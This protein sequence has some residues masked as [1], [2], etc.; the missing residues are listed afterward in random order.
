MQTSLSDA[1]HLAARIDER[2]AAVAGVGRRLGLDDESLVLAALFGFP[3]LAVDLADGTR[4]VNPQAAAGPGVADGM[5]ADA[6]RRAA[7]GHGKRLDAVR[8]AV[9]L[10]QGHVAFLV[11]GQHVGPND[12]LPLQPL[13]VHVALGNQFALLIGRKENNDLVAVADD[14][15]V[16]DDQT[17]LAI[18]ERARAPGN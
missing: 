17:I 2:A 3:V 4:R 18:D 8:D 1:D 6:R 14:V 7:L 10:E 12:I 5:D 13:H 16:G 9:D 15:V 11:L